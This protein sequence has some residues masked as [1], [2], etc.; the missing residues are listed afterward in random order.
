[1]TDIVIHNISKSYAGK[2]V[3]N[4]FSAVVPAGKITCI[5]APSGSGKTTLLRIL[6][7]LEDPD[8][9]QITGLSGLRRSAVFQ[10]DRLCENLNPIANIRLTA[11]HATIEQV[12][13]AMHTVGLVNCES[14]PIC[15]FSG[16]MKRRVAILRALMSQY[17]ILFLDEPF[18][19]LDT[20]TK[21]FV[22]KYTLESCKGFTV[23]LV[24][25][26]PAEAEFFSAGQVIALQE[27]LI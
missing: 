17:D 23:I 19:G 6:M 1:M 12:L 8:R 10:E 9:G 13:E 20:V 26:D 22:M 4:H 16:G 11:A 5:M 7:G 24:T 25:H 18:R 15:E 14:Q 21:E 2:I 3:L 27:S